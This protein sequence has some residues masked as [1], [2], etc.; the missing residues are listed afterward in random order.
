[1]THLPPIQA[2]MS[3]PE[4]APL[5]AFTS[6]CKTNSATSKLYSTSNSDHKLAPMGNPQTAVNMRVLPS[7]PTSPRICDQSPGPEK[8]SGAERLDEEGE[9]VQDPLL[10]PQTDDSST[11]AISQPLFPIEPPIEDAITK[12]MKTSM[13]SVHG[14]VVQPTHEEYRLVLSCV[15]NVGRTYNANPGKYLKRTLQEAENQYWKAKRIRGEPGFK[16]G[17]RPL[18]IVPSSFEGVSSKRPPKKAIKPTS[19]TNGTQRVRKTPK[20][21]PTVQLISSPN[22]KRSTPDF[23]TQPQKRPEDV[24]YQAIPDYAPPLSTLPA[25]N[26]KALKADWSSSNILDL[27]DDPD[28]HLLHEAEVNLAA[29]LRLS[30]ATYLCSKRRIFEACVTLYKNGKPDFRKTNAQ[31]AC[32]IDVNKASKLWTAYDRVGWFSRAHFE[33]WL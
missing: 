13:Q 8:P 28:R 25:G 12:H 14:K 1:M 4:P 19:T 23:R 16:G 27:S 29:T 15:S 21:S 24:D 17:V 22:G 33:K 9:H 6:P 5:D 10:Y 31:Q 32:K 18:T 3:P 20:N 26:S 7:P 11:G 2:L 30:C